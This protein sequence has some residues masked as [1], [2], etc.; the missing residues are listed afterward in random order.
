M[1][2]ENIKIYLPEFIDG[3]LDLTKAEKIK[4]H[5]EE[6]ESCKKIYTEL[7]SFINLTDSFP[8]IETPDGMKEEFLALAEIDKNSQKKKIFFPLWIKIAAIVVFAFGT[9]LSGYFTGSKGNETKLYQAELG[10]MQQEVLL[11]N[12]RQL[13]GPQKI[14]A[15]Y[16]TKMLDQPANN[17]IDALVY[18]MNSDNNDNVRLAAINALSGMMEKNENIKTE[19]INSLSVQENPLLQI[20]LIQVL[21]E[22]GVKESKEVIESISNDENTNQNVKTYA[23]DMIKTII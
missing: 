5:L 6:C 8:V 23:K 17:L 15:V 9:F 21:T 4:T 13:S 7:H 1:N 12:L 3:K 20:S 18:T 22:F 14:Q 19:L 11:A 2:C 16:D 10:K